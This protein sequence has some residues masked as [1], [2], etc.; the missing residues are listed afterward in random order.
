MYIRLNSSSSS[1]YKSWATTRG[2]TASQRGFTTATT[3]IDAISGVPRS[4]YTNGR[5]IVHGWIHQYANTAAEKCGYIKSFMPR[6]SSASTNGA[7]MYEAI[8]EYA[9]TSAITAIS[10]FAGVSA[11]AQTFASGSK[12]YIYGVK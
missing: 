9:S 1:L 5:G 3:Q 8:F 11:T 4:S 12:F 6:G 7:N 2:A 10:F